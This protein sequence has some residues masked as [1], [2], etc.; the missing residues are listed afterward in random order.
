MNGM[1]IK[2]I[3]LILLIA[4]VSSCTAIFEDGKE[5]ASVLKKD[6]NQMHVDSLRA[7]IDNGESFLLIDVRQ[8]A[9]YEAGNI[10][11]SFNIPRGEL[12]F[13]ITD[14]YYWEEQYMYVPIKED[15]III[16]CKVGDRGNLAS[17]SLQKLGFTNVYNLEGGYT[18]FAGDKAP[19]AL[20]VES[21]GCGG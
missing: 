10:T 20:K 12:E 18:A 9:E 11:G 4:I 7:L 16:Y 15:L 8:P 13:L 2:P 21:G 1:K 5:M 14:E 19:A 17:K 6:V 3:I